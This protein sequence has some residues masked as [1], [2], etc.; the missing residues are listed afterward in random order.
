M[1][2]LHINSEK[3]AYMIDQLIKDGK[4]LDDGIVVEPEEKNTPQKQIDSEKGN[5]NLEQPLL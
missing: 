4:Y 5:S 2:L 1:L 3:D